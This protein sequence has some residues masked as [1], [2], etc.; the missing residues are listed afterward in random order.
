MIGAEVLKGKRSP[1]S[2][3]SWG[4]CGEEGGGVAGVGPR[5]VALPEDRGFF[6][7]LTVGS[8][9]GAGLYIG[10]GQPQG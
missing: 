8:G 6:F 9:L 5:D 3:S 1:V 2:S 4:S 10:V 7:F